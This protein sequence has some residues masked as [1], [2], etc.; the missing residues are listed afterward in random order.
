[1]KGDATP[2]PSCLMFGL[3]LCRCAL[4]LLRG[5]HRGHRHEDKRMARPGDEGMRR[6][7]KMR[8]KRRRRR[9]R[10]KQPRERDTATRGRHQGK[11]AL[12]S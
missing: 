3:C 8:K 2:N 11:G 6:R 1:M 7:R 12:R 4:E 10:K 9:K 5:A